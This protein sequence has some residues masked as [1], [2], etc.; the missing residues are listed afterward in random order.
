MKK[1][2]A[3]LM[4]AAA[5]FGANA[6]VVLTQNGNVCSPDEPV[7]IKAVE[8]AI[9]LGD[10]QYFYIVECGMGDPKLLNQGSSTANIKVTLDTEDYKNIQWCGITEQCMPMPSKTEVRQGSI[11]AG[12]TIPIE[13]HGSFAGGP[14]SYA[15]YVVKMTVETGGKSEVYTLHLVYDETCTAGISHVTADGTASHVVYDLSGRI[16]NHT[17]PG[18]VYIRDGKKFLQR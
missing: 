15:T 14:E 16:V 9:D 1:I 13:V 7:V 17:V 4:M 5:A 2:Y 8:E 11:A 10:G 18:H 6:Q 3:F 12:K